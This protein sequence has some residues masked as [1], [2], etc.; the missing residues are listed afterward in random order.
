MEIILS[1]FIGI[2][3]A[4]A[5]GFRI[6]IPFLIVSIASYSGYLELSTNFHWIGTM[7]ALVLF[8]VAT[9]AEVFSYYIP[10]VDNFLDAVS[11]PLAIFA[12]I[13][14]SGAVVTDFPPLIKWSLA[15]IAGGG[16]AGTIHAATGLIRLK[17][18]ALTGGIGNP[19]V[20]TAEAGSSIALSSIAIF[21]PALSAAIVGV[22]VVYFSFMIKRKFLSPPTES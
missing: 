1:I 4:A 16:I 17:S 19:V 15:L 14:L 2:G 3:L 7:P 22:I 10:W 9:V 5:V 13:V 11:H 12:G 20:S 21:I 8:A 6:F 18:S